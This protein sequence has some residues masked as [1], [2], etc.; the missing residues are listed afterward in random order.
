M[1]SL[2]GSLPAFA[3]IQNRLSPFGHVATYV[4]SLLVFVIAYAVRA[5]FDPVL[6]QGFPFLT[7]FPAVILCGFAFGTRQ[8]LLV[9][10]LSG[11]TAWYCFISPGRFDLSAG[12]L[13]AMGLYIFVVTTDLLLIHLV[14]RAYRTETSARREIERLA[15]QQ[16][17]MAK[18]LDHR[19]K[20]TFATINAII[21]LSLKNA[22]SAPEL[23]DRLR[24]RLGAL[25]RSNLLLRGA[26]D[27]ARASLEE[28]AGQALEP[29]SIV[30]TQRLNMEG[31]RVPIDGQ[32]LVVLSLILHELG[33]NAAKY[34]AL[35]VAGGHISLTWRVATTGPDKQKR[36]EITWRETGG[37]APAVTTPASGG[38]G[39]I[40]VQRVV[41]SIQGEAELSFPET[42]ALATL[43]LPLAEQPLS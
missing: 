15:D 25:G 17:V 8:G 10:A 2:I 32:T 14:I 36:L 9:A 22:S 13:L 39:S 11:V 3:S 12:T 18:E 4:G 16:E 42:G 24:D 19:L 30:G 1:R 27:G 28:I 29:F 33:M 34:G 31:P 35:S 6:P 20:N 37:P 40:L 5:W 38:F 21:S 7:F 26:G 41:T 23:A 43:T